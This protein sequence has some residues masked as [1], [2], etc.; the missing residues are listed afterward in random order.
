M[1]RKTMVCFETKFIVHKVVRQ[2]LTGNVSYTVWFAYGLNLKCC[3]YE[4][5]RSCKTCTSVTALRGRV[6]TRFRSQKVT[7]PIFVSWCLQVRL[8]NNS[9][10]FITTLL[11][12]CLFFSVVS[13]SV[14]IQ[15]PPYEQV[16]VSLL[17]CSHRRAAFAVMV[18]S[19]VLFPSTKQMKIWRCEVKAAAGLIRQHQPPELRDGLS[20]VHTCLSPGIM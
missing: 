8:V 3:H 19:Q 12:L 14:N 5:L 9:Q 2:S 11:K 20:N 1:T 15:L 16:R 13:M 18:S 6:L 17:L 10:N 7:P 4:T